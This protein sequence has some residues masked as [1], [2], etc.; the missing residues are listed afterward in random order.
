ML[1][2]VAAGTSRRSLTENYVKDCVG[3]RVARFNVA[4]DVRFVDALLRNPTGKVVRRL[5]DATP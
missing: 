2:A 1:G 4:R 5:L 3:Q